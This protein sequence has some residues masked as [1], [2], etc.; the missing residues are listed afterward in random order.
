MLHR[1]GRIWF[2]GHLQDLGKPA[3]GV[4]IRDL[5]RDQRVFHPKVNGLGLIKNKEHGFVMGQRCRAATQA[6]GAGLIRA[7]ERRFENVIE[8]LAV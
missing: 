2:D 3:L 1:I 7:H 4:E 8:V 6:L 5:K